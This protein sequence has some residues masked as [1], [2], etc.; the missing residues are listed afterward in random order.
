[1]LR[2]LRING[3][4]KYKM[5]DKLIRNKSI[6][7]KFKERNNERFCRSGDKAVFTG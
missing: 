2:K 5:K 1:M 3:G 7:L 6:I 4:Y